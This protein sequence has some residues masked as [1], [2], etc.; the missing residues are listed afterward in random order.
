MIIRLFGCLLRCLVPYKQRIMHM[1]VAAALSSSVTEWLNM[2]CMCWESGQKL[3]CTTQTADEMWFRQLWITWEAILWQ[4]QYSVGSFWIM[5]TWYGL[6]IIKEARRC[7]KW[8]VSHPENRHG[9]TSWKNSILPGK[10]SLCIG[11]QRHFLPATQ[12]KPRGHKQTSVWQADLI[13]SWCVYWYA[14]PALS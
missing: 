9:T 2:T 10:C 12:R 11:F 6:K 5:I 4:R 7:C 13:T 8:V 14:G 3:M 1:Y